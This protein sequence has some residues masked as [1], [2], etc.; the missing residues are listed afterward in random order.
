MATPGS[1]WTAG[2]VLFTNRATPGSNERRR[3]DLDAPASSFRRAVLAALGLEGDAEALRFHVASDAFDD[4]DDASDDGWTSVA[5]TRP[6]R[7]GLALDENDR[8][9]TLDENDEIVE[10]CAALLGPGPLAG[11][12]VDWPRTAAAGLSPRPRPRDK[13]GVICAGSGRYRCL[14]DAS[15]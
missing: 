5:K 15:S 14:R 8:R 9:T 13:A 11:A 12:E 7:R 10:T 3:Y 4:D 6:R 1:I 2:V